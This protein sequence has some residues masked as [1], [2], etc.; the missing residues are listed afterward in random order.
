[1]HKLD[2]RFY[3]KNFKTFIL[4]TSLFIII[5]YLFL[6][7]YNPYRMDDAWFASFIYNYYFKGVETDMVFGGDITNGVGGTQLFGK[8]Y[9]IIYATGL[10]LLGVT[11]TKSSFYL[12]STVL[13]ILSSLVWYSILNLLKFNRRHALIFCL[14]FLYLD[15]FFSA[16]HSVRSEVF[17]LLLSSLSLR[18]TLAKN[19]ARAVLF[20][21]LALE[22]HPVGSVSFF[23]NLPV[24][25]DQRRWLARHFKRFLRQVIWSLVVSLLLYVILH[26]AYLYRLLELRNIAFDLRDN[27]LYRYYFVTRYYRHLPELFLIL[28]T[29]YLYFRLPHK[30][31]IMVQFLISMLVFSLLLGRGTFSYAVLIYPAV[32]LFIFYTFIQINR[33][34]W[35]IVLLLS[36]YTPQYLFLFY[37]SQEVTEDYKSFLLNQLPASNLPI[38][39]LPNDYFAVLFT[40]TFYNLCYVNPELFHKT[41]TT[42]LLI[43]HE[44]SELK[45]YYA[46]LPC[47]NLKNIQEN[48]SKYQIKE[49]NYVNQPLVIYKISRIN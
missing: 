25:L 20:T 21:A 15:I 2:N 19:Y 41:L 14:S 7:D 17:I 23:M 12:I 34:S 1:M 46:E 9:A 36:L 29:C 4:I 8:I 6:K 26:Y 42:A 35:L 13:L 48:Y 10:E 18:E 49:V 43:E 16:A 40:H 22:T 27:F 37:T 11:W 5:I 38:V 30:R 31:L 24:L 33:L 3:E 28:I 44:P 32:L 47:D 39:G 45:R